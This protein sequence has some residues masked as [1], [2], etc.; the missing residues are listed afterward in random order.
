MSIIPALPT[1]H[2]L[3]LSPILQVCGAALRVCL[4]FVGMMALPAHIETGIAAGQ[5]ASLQNSTTEPPEPGEAFH[6]ALYHM[7]EDN[8]AQALAYFEHIEQQNHLSGPLY[9]N[10]GLAHLALEATGHAAAAFHHATRFRETREQAQLG[11][12]YI[13]HRL[14]QNGTWIPYLPR[15]AFADRLLFN[16]CY[17]CWGIG[18]LVLLNAGALLLAF[19]WLTGRNTLLCQAGAVLA[20]AGLGLLLL[21]G[22]LSLLSRGYTR[23]VIVHEQVGLLAE[24]GSALPQSARLL[25]QTDTGA[26][27]GTNQSALETTFRA[28]EGLIDLAYEAYTVTL[29]Q[30]TSRRHPGWV[31]VRL[32]NGLGG[33]VPEH[34]VVPVP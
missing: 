30:R 17:F 26:D 13:E 10:M 4:L 28:P 6:R 18:A 7:S 25:S 24:P 29:Y 21:V 16:V 22:A 20:P 5:P 27:N 15:H 19:A 9:Y 3:S 32:R 2:R 34:A 14:E 11:L 23:A 8:H 33:W 31:Y 1:P 12:A